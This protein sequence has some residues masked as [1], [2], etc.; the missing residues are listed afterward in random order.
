MSTRE[1]LLAHLWSEVINPNLRSHGLDQAIAYARARPD[2][3]FAD[4]GP[5]M[6]RLRALGADPRDICLLMRHAA[7]EAVFGTLYAIGDPGVDGGKVFMLHEDL[8]G[9]D[10]SGMEGRPGSADAVLRSG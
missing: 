2:E 4:S 9:A 3:P 5:A 6:E 1:E 10:P 7:Y 8:L